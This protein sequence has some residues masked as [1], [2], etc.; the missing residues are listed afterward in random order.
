[1]SAAPG[2]LYSVA[3]PIGNVDDLS[4]HA[5]ETLEKADIIACENATKL[6]D[7]LRRAQ[8][9]TKARF[10]TYH[11][12]NEKIS[13]KGLVELLAAGK[14]VALVVS[15]G[16]P[17]ISDPGYHIVRSAYESNI[18]VRAVPGA[19]AMA[20]AMSICPLPVDPFLFLGFISPKS[21]RRDNILKKYGD[22]EGTVGFYESVHRIDKLLEAILANWGDVEAFV[23][24][25]LT[26]Q[27]ENIYWGSLSASLDWLKENKKGE[28]VVFVHK[29]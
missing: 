12:H 18:R 16:T 5:R 26:K 22:F 14:D 7:L 4:R 27:H 17:R 25:E 13:A 21:G 8:I 28:F 6:K 29:A 1:M 3:V 20:A 10:L 11:S 9:D 19:S 2:N 23:V 15:A 24:R